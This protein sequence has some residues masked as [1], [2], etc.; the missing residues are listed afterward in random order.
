M[1]AFIGML[2]PGALA[3]IMFGMG[4]RLTLG[5]FTR[6]ARYP[7]AVSTGLV[8]QMLL[9]PLLGL[10]IAMLVPMRPE[11]AVGIMVIALS[12]GGAVSNL[13]TLLGRGDIALSVTLTAVSSVI[14][15]FSVPILLN[16]ALEVLLGHGRLIHLP[17]LA[18]MGRVAL[19]TVLPVCL[20][21]V[22]NAWWP[23]LAERAEQPLK[24]A[25]YGFMALAVALI[26][27][28]ERANFGDYLLTAGPAAV[29]LTL[30]AMAMG[31]TLARLS[32]LP[33]NQVVTLTIEVGIQNA[34]LATAIAVSPAM[35]GSTTIAIVPTVY[36]F[37]MAVV[38][39]GYIMW[40]NRRAGE[41]PPG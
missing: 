24:V 19:I 37:T 18:T 31:N 27:M 40:L 32:A 13:F 1:K 9:L 12:P 25:S 6:L 20:G 28:R 36:G 26:L 29:A 11:F 38:A 22:I 14:S 3:I 15:V 21:M 8:C 4:M 34:I 16:L 30:L 2:I 17:V 41:L 39:F 5:D 10:G 7:R 35:L 23:R 33:A